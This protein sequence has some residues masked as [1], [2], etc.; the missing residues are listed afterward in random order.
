MF[1]L[2][3]LA[4]MIAFL[5]VVSCEGPEGPEGPAGPKGDKGD[6]GATGA[7][8]QTGP[9]GQDGEDGQDGNANVAVIKLLADDITWTEEEIFGVQ[10]NTFVLES[11]AVN[12]DV[13][14]HGAVF[15]YCSVNGEWTQLPLE[16]VLPDGSLDIHF[17]YTYALNRIKL[18]TYATTENAYELVPVSEYKF[19]LITGN[20]VPGSK[21]ASNEESITTM[22]RKAG[23]DISNLEE[24]LEYYGIEY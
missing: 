23:V 19:L 15:G 2:T 12:E 10:A 8:G 17:I 24:V 18:I 4:I 20:I 6:T 3:N 7:T 13:I 1:K 22:L 5:G 16:L 9:A 11:D 14:D 21:G